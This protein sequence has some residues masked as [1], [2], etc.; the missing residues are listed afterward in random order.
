VVTSS[1]V[2]EGNGIIRQFVGGY[3]DMRNWYDEKAAIAKKMNDDLEKR[4]KSK[5]EHE[6]PVAS[7]STR[8]NKKLSYKDNKELEDLPK[9]IEKMEE[10]QEGLQEQ[11]NAPDFFQK[12]ADA[13]QSVFSKLADLEKRLSDAY[14]RWDELESLKNNEQ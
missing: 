1:L 5:V 12:D 9:I 8:S 3:T 7:T 14:Q 2:F 10:E 6:K 4:T 13:T 11:V